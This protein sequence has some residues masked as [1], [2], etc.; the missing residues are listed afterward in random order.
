MSY[1]GPLT[2]ERIHRGL[3][4][5]CRFFMWMNTFVGDP[6]WFFGASQGS[7]LMDIRKVDGFVWVLGKPEPWRLF[8]RIPVQ[9]KTWREDMIDDVSPNKPVYILQNAQMPPHII[10]RN[11][12]EKLEAARDMDFEP[13]MRAIMS[14]PISREESELVGKVEMSRVKGHELYLI[15][16]HANEVDPN[17]KLEW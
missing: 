5:E 2:E 12:F 7:A 9:I 1:Y 10:R 16:T 3:L 6:D 15:A 11:A 8:R 17:K 4:A 14:R 13:F